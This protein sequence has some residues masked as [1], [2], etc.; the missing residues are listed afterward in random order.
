MEAI[1]F[2]SEEMMEILPPVTPELIASDVQTIKAALSQ[3]RQE[4]E[5]TEYVA[6]SCVP[7][8]HK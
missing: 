2:T 8:Q 7:S 4:E 1:K 3:L 5:E 6:F